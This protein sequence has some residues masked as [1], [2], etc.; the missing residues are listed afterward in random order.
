MLSYS[1]S[2]TIALLLFFLVS[3]V[4]TSADTKKPYLAPHEQMVFDALDNING[5]FHAFKAVFAKNAEIELVFGEDSDGTFVT[6]SG[7]VDGV[8]SGFKK[9][10]Q[11]QV[12]WEPVT[13]TDAKH[14]EDGVLAAKYWN[15]GLHENGCE[16]LFSGVGTI[17]VSIILSFI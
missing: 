13:N 17:R 14:P 7:S 16:A 1:M 9:M 10:V 2:T 6:K 8:F 11:Y 5:D 12:K 15:Y 3:V 4:F